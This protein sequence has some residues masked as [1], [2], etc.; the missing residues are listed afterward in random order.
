MLVLSQSWAPGWKAKI[1]GHTAPVLRADGFVQ[2]VPVPAGVHNVVLTYD[3]PGLRLG[4][5]LSMTTI[6]GLLAGG[7]WFNRRARQRPAA[8]SHR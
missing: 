1:D 5:L 7:W 8:P 2:G 3:A 4:E 6:A